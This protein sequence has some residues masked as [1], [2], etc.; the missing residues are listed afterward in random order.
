MSQS[1]GG[2]FCTILKGHAN[3]IDLFGGVKWFLQ[4]SETRLITMSHSTRG[5]GLNI[6][7]LT[8]Q[9]RQFQ[10]SPTHPQSHQPIHPATWTGLIGAFS[11]LHF[12]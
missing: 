2:S 3:I 10:F 7:S 12:E 1:A 9:F 4:D 11:E 6:L 5:A 8:I